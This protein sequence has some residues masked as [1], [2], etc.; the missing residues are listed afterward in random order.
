MYVVGGGGRFAKKQVLSC[1]KCFSTLRE[2]NQSRGGHGGYMLIAQ[3]YSTYLG[4]YVFVP[5]QEQP[6]GYI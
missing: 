6:G 1:C 3:M 4:R 5:T 2:F